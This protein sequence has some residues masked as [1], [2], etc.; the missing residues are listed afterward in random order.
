MRALAFVLPC[1]LAAPALAQQAPS[2]EDAKKAIVADY[3]KEQPKDKVLEVSAAEESDF[4]FIALCH[5]ANVLVERE[6][7]T[8]SANYVQRL[9]RARGRTRRS[10]S[11]N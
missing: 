8:R 4:R 11:T 9:G 7:K 1:A 5:F 6:D 2:W 3:K 10:T